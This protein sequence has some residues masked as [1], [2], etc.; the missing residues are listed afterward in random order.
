MST[1]TLGRRPEADDQIRLA[2][3]PGGGLVQV[4]IT[5]QDRKAVLRGMGVSQGWK[6]AFAMREAGEP[7]ERIERRFAIDPAVLRRGLAEMYA[8]LESELHAMA[9][10]RARLLR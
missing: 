1:V 8:R 6:E 3:R 2:P 7:W 5:T 9:S 4:I 10:R